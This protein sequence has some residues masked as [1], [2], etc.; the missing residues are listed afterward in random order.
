MILGQLRL[1]ESPTTCGA[2]SGGNFCK[3]T[4]FF[5]PRR[6]LVNGF[7]SSILI[8]LTKCLSGHKFLGSLFECIVYQNVFVFVI[9]LL[10]RS[11]RL[12]HVS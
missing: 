3:I 11:C 2:L 1:G 5:G 8:T 9:V 6:D 4:G 7:V 10:A 12:T